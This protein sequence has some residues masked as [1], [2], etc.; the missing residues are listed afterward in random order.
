MMMAAPSV[1]EAGVA[2]VEGTGDVVWHP[3]PSSSATRRRMREPRGE[4][5]KGCI[6][7]VWGWRM[8]IAPASHCEGSSLDQSVTHARHLARLVWLLLHEP[9][10]IDDQKAT[11]RLL[12]AASRDETV[13]LA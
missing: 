2:A 9:D 5:V 11:L 1:R 12:V 7:Y 6:A 10:N 8:L 13:N 4:V 3:T